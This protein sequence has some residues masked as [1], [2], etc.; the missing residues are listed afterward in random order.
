MQLYQH[1]SHF[2][3]AQKRHFLPNAYK[4]PNQAQSAHVLPYSSHMFLNTPICPFIHLYIHSQ[5]YQLCYYLYIQFLALLA[6]LLSVYLIPSSANP[7]IDYPCVS[8]FTYSCTF[9]WTLF[10]L[11]RS[12]RALEGFDFVIELAE[13]NVLL[14]HF[15]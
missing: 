1:Q 7:A 6:L 5:L 9:I 8:L 13:F 2:K 15:A 14:I 4:L 10:V 3:S 12:L 11:R